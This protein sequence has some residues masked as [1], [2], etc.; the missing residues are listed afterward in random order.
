MRVELHSCFLLH[1][2]AYRETSLLLEVFSKEHGRVGLVSKG[3]A[4]KK[5][6]NRNLQ[7][8]IPLQMSWTGRGE[9][10]NLINAEPEGQPML[11]TGDK[12]FLG[13]YL[14]EL[15]IRLLHRHDPYSQL[16]D[17]YSLVLKELV[18]TSCQETTLRLFEKRM[19]EELGYGLI[20]DHEVSSGTKIVPEASYDY[21]SGEGPRLINSASVKTNGVRITGE[22]IQILQMETLLKSKENRAEA[23]RL[24]RYLLAPILGDKPLKT[25]KIFKTMKLNEVIQ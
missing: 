23:K 16:F 19:L 7:A 21:V 17:I 12:L 10:G 11:L 15:L 3:G 5:L 4:N 20:L 1:K 13:Y 14:N 6:L 24:M 8:F 2:K 9:L 22:T 18:E 25:K